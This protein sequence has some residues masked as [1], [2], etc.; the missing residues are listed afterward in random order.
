MRHRKIRSKLNRT[1]EHRKA[2]M[3]NLAIALIREERIHTTDAKA[4]Q[5]RP[6]VERLITLGKDGSLHA[7]RQAFGELNDKRAVHRL[8]TEVAPR[9]MERNGGYTRIV[10]DAPRQGDGALMSFI[11]L[12][13]REEKEVK[14]KPKKKRERPAMPRF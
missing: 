7:R 3:R 6:F 1:T 9:F 4:K 11:E 13:E 5:L 12:V 10:K 2:L 8:F 14:P